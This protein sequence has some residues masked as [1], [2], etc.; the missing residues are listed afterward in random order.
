MQISGAIE[1]LT[2]ERTTT[3]EIKKLAI[4]EGMKTMIE[5]GFEKVRQGITSIEEIM[6]VI[7]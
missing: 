3:D 1:R 5:D 7:A 2:V 6:R 4:S